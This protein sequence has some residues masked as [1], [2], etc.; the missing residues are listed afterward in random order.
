MGGGGCHGKDSKAGEELWDG[1]RLDAHPKKIA[2]QA[3]NMEA[4]ARD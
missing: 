3:S 4:H 2:A 1:V